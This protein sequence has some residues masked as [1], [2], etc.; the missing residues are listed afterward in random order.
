MTGAGSGW[1]AQPEQDDGQEDWPA[2]EDRRWVA[3][4]RGANRTGTLTAVAW[5]FSSRGVNFE[6]LATGDI[7][8]DSGL[9]VITFR[10]SERRQRLLARTVDRL[11]AVRSVVVRREDDPSVGA[12]GVVHLPPGV[13]FV[14]PPEAAVRWS[15]DSMAGQPVLVEG[16]LADVE[17][18]TSHATVCGATAVATVVLPLR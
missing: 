2:G 1:D 12:V 6:S 8:G 5:V 16:S 3:F 11:S 10:A 18:V 17:L 14:P 15:G 7:D 13:R 9:I 4:V